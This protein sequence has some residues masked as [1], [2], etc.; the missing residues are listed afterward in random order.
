MGRPP[1]SSIFGTY[2]RKID[3]AFIP[4]VYQTGPGCVRPSVWQLGARTPVES[5]WRFGMET[6][7]ILVLF[8]LALSIVRD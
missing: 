6:L 3:N 8:V 4:R 7:G 5:T 1:G 2:S